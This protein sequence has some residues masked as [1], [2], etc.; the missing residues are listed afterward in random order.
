MARDSDLTTTNP[1]NDFL[2]LLPDATAAGARAFAARMRA[3]VIEQLKQEP[4][5]WIRTFPESALAARAKG[6]AISQ[7]EAQLRRRAT[8]KKTPEMGGPTGERRHSSA[9]RAATS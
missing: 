9:M 4:T 6:S 1:R 5:F 7:S 8:D 2:I 3:T